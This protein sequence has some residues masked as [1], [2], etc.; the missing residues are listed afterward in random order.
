M[1]TSILNFPQTFPAMLYIYVKEACS[2]ASS[3]LY[4]MFYKLNCIKKYGST[5]YFIRITQ[6]L[7][8]PPILSQR[9]ILIL[10]H[11]NYWQFVKCKHTCICLSYWKLFMHWRVE[12]N[13]KLLNTIIEQEY[14][15]GS[16][17]HAILSKN[18]LPPSKFYP[19]Y[20][21]C[22]SVKVELC[23]N[24]WRSRGVLRMHVRKQISSSQC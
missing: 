11:F 10:P 9:Y 16:V 13:L 14:K 17:F 22:M 7:K 15:R 20:K 19:Y 24:A 23:R 3:N 18:F 5:S 2:M 12:D 8:R 21:H 4:L 6:V 1:Q